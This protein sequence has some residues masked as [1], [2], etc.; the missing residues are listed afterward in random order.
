MLRDMES[1][2]E[3]LHPDSQGAGIFCVALCI[4]IM[5]LAV[6]GYQLAAGISASHPGWSA[7]IAYLGV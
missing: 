4:A 7:T 3:A 2:A 5:G 6:A 1:K